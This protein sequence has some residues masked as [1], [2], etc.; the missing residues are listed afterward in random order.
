[1]DV[2]AQFFRESLE[3]HNV[4][5]HDNG[6]MS[7]IP[8]RT[9]VFIPEMSV[10]DPTKDYVKVPNVILLVRENLL[11]LFYDNFSRYELQL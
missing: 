7:F 1:M 11:D 3:N 9:V 6:T 2:S 8:K 10:S 5:F 4:T